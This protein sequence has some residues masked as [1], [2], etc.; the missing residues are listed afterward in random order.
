MAHCHK[1]EQAYEL[2][3]EIQKHLNTFR[4][5]SVTLQLFLADTPCK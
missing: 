3:S 2:L 1:V 4:L 5:A